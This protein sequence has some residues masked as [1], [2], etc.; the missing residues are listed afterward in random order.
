MK[1]SIIIYLDWLPLIMSLDDSKRLRLYDFL[2]SGDRSIHLIE[3]NH[4]KGILSYILAQI[5]ENDKKYDEKCTKAKENIKKRWEKLNT[6]VYGSIQSNTNVYE[7][8]LNVNVNDKDNDKDNVND[9]DKDKDKDNV[10]IINDNS[11]LNK[12][13]AHKFFL[14]AEFSE[15]WTEFIAT[16]KKKKAV[17]SPKVLLNQLEKLDKLS[18]GSLQNAIEIVTKSVNSGWSDLYELKNNS[19]GINKS[20]YSINEKAASINRMEDL[21]RAVIQSASSQDL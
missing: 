2:F 4:L 21:A 6:N 10:I 18:G 20:Q 15:I 14:S 17:T 16:K 19:N 7:G 13:K 9:K 3:D 12:Y 1:K 5:S 8:I 11:I